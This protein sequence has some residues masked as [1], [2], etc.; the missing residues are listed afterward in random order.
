MTNY[1]KMRALLVENGMNE[2]ISRLFVR[3]FRID[4][5]TFSCDEGT[6]EWAMTRGFFPSRVQLYGLNEQN[7]QNYLPD[8][9]DF[10]LHPY[11]NHFVIWVNDKLSLK[12]TLGSVFADALPEYYLYIENDGE[13]TYLMDAPA[14]IA[15]DK[16]FIL[17]LLKRKGVLIIKPNS[18]TSGGYGV[19]KAEWTGDGVCINN[20]E[21]F[22][23]DAFVERINKLRNNIVT[24]YAYQH[25]ALK[26]IWHS[27][28]CTLRVIM[29][30]LPREQF[31][32]MPKWKCIVS[33][34]RFGTE[35]SGGASN[36]S[37][38]G[39]GIGFDFQTGKFNEFGIR[40]KQFCPD[41]DWRCYYHPDTKVI[42]KE[43]GLPNW[44]Y[45]RDTIYKVCRHYDSLNHLGLDIIIT[46]EGF[47]FCEI[48][49]KPALNYEQVMCGPVLADGENRAY[50]KSKGLEKINKGKFYAIYQACQE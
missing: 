6:K 48:N 45:V 35:V 50:F 21:Y 13:Y 18:S 7:F 49:S 8:Y 39:I 11:N 5:E 40:Y 3:K 29:V 37:S 34:A 26:K 10:M 14:D 22:T 28:E 23:E 42:W 41:G 20:R 27:T 4:E 9:C 36:L 24:E 15:K 38:G 12:Y 43:T 31:Y 17:N 30:K 33:Y 46:Q 1:E 19:M 16:G 47:V 25:S 44:D 32:M 2:R